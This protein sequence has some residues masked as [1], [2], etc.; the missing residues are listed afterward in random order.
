MKEDKFILICAVCVLIFCKFWDLFT[1]DSMDTLISENV[2]VTDGSYVPQKA[3]KKTDNT[4]KISVV[5]CGSSFSSE[6]S[7]KVVNGKSSTQY[8]AKSVIR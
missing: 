1:I 5:G 7:A 6:N 3:D 2:F 4:P 8:T